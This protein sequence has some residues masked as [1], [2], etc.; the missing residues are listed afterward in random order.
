MRQ[1][2]FEQHYKNNYEAL[3]SFAMK[4]ARN[5]MDADDLMQETA[6]K[7]YKNFNSFMEGSNFKNWSFT[8]LKNTFI[9]KYRKRKKLNVVNLP[10]ED[11]EHA[12]VVETTE[13]K[14]QT[15]HTLTSLKNCIDTLSEKSKVPFV[16][17]INGYQ[18]SEIS[19]SLDIPMGTVKSRISYA[20]TKLKTLVSNT[21][22]A[23]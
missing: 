8:I 13:P 17:Y 3:S 21:K 22:M 4:L 19:E 20:R 16:M 9:T 2:Q 12:V 7:A 23:S 5:R 14:A 15:S 18:Y 10:V 6:I 11:M 1:L